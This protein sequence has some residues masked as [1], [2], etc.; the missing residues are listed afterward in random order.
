MAYIV[1]YDPLDGELIPDGKVDEACQSIVGYISANPNWAGYEHVRK[2]ANGLLIDALRVEIKEG[3]IPLHA[4][5]FRFQGQLLK[6][7]KD[8]RMWDWPPGFHDQEENYLMRLL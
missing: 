4:L 8:G 2:I 5:V 1:E 7:N 3:H 6:V